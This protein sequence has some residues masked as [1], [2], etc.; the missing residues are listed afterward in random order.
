MCKNTDFILKIIFYKSATFLSI[1]LSELWLSD[2]LHVQCLSFCEIP[3]GIQWNLYQ[4]NMATS[5][6]CPD[7]P[8][9]TTTFVQTDRHIH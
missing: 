8:I 3:V 5:L 7:S 9:S 1:L 6:Q 2:M 4:A